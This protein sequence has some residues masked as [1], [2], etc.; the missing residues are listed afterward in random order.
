MFNSTYEL[1]IAYYILGREFLDHGVPLNNCDPM[2]VPFSLMTH[3]LLRASHIILKIPCI[4][5]SQIRH[6]RHNCF[7]II[8]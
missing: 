7:I 1:Y 3:Q 5:S 8:K 4:K 2:T 6:N